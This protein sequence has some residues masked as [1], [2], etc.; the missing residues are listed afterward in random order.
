MGSIDPDL[1]C[2]RDHTNNLTGQKTECQCPDPQ[3]WFLNEPRPSLPARKME[4]FILLIMQ[5]EGDFFFFSMSSPPLW[6]PA[7]NDQSCL[8]SPLGGT[9]PSLSSA[10]I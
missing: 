6:H 5:T 4:E 3:F 7:L 10:N 9:Q 1:R 8:Q 2:A